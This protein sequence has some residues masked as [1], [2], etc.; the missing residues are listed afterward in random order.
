MN[1]DQHR[2]LTAMRGGG[3]FVLWPMMR[4][5]FLRRKWIIAAG[6]AIA[7]SD[8]RRAKAPKRPWLVTRRGLAALRAFERE[9]ASGPVLRRPRQLFMKPQVDEGICE[10]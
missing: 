10:P 7:P 5:A 2:V 6:E 9:H 1:P 3:D 4:R 8:K